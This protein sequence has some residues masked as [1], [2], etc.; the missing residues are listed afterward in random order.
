MDVSGSLI[1]TGINFPAIKQATPEKN[2]M[3]GPGQAAPEYHPNGA[4]N[5]NESRSTLNTADLMRKVEAIQSTRVQ[6]DSAYET[7]S[8][9]GQQAITSYQQTQNYSQAFDEGELVGID[10]YV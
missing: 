1:S 4:T 5:R 3:R 6:K 8:F 9:K 2:L 10:L 7:A